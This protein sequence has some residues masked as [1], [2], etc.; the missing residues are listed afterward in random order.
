MALAAESATGVLIGM[1]VRD[2]HIPLIKTM[3][4][5]FVRRCEGGITAEASLSEEDYGRIHEE[6]RGEVWV[7]CKVV[8]ESGEEP[9]V[10]SMLWAWVA[11]Q[12]KSEP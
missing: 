2:T 6:D 10:A 1:N 12:K 3:K 7:P 8:D 11:K 5:D 9:I 4:V